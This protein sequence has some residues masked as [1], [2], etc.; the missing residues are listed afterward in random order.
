MNID[1]RNTLACLDKIKKDD[2]SKTLIYPLPHMYIVK[3]LVPGSRSA[4]HPHM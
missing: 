4:I 1:G 3:D 2:D